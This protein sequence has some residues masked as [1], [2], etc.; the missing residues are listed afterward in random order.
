MTL[1]SSGNVGIGTA[2]PSGSGQILH[3]NGS[4]TVADFHMT[5]SSSGSTASDGFVLRYSGANAEFLNREAGSN[6]FYTSGTER[7][8]IISNGT[9]LFGTTS[10]YAS[11]QTVQVN[12]YKSNP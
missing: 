12:C 2:S 6:I 7:S 3:L 10:E 4:S 8:R 9:T 11:N 5:N 1:N